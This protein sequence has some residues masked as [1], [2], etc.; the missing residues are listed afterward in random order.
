MPVLG[1]DVA[2][3]ATVLYRGTIH[4]KIED[5]QSE[6]KSNSYNIKRG[7]FLYLLLMAWMLDN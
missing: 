3:V 4:S 6:A 5:C 1:N 2:W 7:E